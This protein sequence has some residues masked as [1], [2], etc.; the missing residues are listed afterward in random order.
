[1]R[2]FQL[3]NVKYDEK[4]KKW[5]FHRGR[6]F[7]EKD[8]FISFKTKKEADKFQR[9]ASKFI[10]NYYVQ[11]NDLYIDVYTLYRQYYFQ[12]SYADN[13][14]YSLKDNF[15][16]IV[17]KFDRW[18]FWQTKKGNF[19]G[20]TFDAPTFING[21]L[22][23]CLGILRDIAKSK[24]DT[25]KVYHIDNKLRYLNYL[26]DEMRDFEMNFNK[27][28]RV[29]SFKDLISTNNKMTG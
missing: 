18:T 11:L 28:A 4:R 1:M 5:K 17:F 26:S 10:Y 21:A 2:K 16:A 24:S 13:F 25:S 9:Y 27:P 22:R 12:F 15:E 14:H 29:Y 20:Y 6:Q 7:D 3:D 8:S 23:N 19:S